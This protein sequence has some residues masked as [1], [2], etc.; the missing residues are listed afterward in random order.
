MKMFRSRSAV[1]VTAAAALSLTATPALARDRHR[2]HD[3]GID[4]GDVLAGLLIVGGIAAIAS[5]AS[6]KA[7]KDR[8]A[9]EDA[10]TRDDYRGDYRSNDGRPYDDYAG[11]LPQNPN[12]TPRADYGDAR[13]DAW[14]DQPGTANRGG[15]GVD[16]AVDACVGEVERGGDSARSVDTIDGVNREGQGWRVAGRVRGGY[17]FSCVVDRDG[18]VKSVAGL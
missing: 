2:H 18:R 11:D 12:G 9:R 7:K 10:R 17:G 14:R 1:L 3:R 5:A 13:S 6:N 16:G 4:G 15:Y 8:Q